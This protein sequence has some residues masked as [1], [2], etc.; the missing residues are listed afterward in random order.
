MFV[1]RRVSHGIFEGEKR[2]NMTL[3][4][5]FFVCAFF[6]SIF[7]DLMVLVL[8]VSCW[9]I[10]G[11]HGPL[12]T[13]LTPLAVYWLIVYKL[14]LV[15]FRIRVAYNRDS[16]KNHQFWGQQIWAAGWRVRLGM[17]FFPLR[18]DT[19]RAE[20]LSLL[21]KS[22]KKVP[23]ESSSHFHCVACGWFNALFWTLAGS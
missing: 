11:F 4:T 2:G 23:P 17:S 15:W 7:L 22:V 13:F 12:P 8:V 3:L 14:R 19:F 1:Y 18:L 5:H 10:I 9:W 20:F 16:K 21:Y 6:P